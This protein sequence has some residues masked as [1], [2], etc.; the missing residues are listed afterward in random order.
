MLTDPNCSA[1]SQLSALR[2]GD[3][4]KASCNLLQSSLNRTQKDV[5]A[6]DGS[7]GGP[8]RREFTTEKRAG[9]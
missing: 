3:M 2:L 4:P 5:L 7:Q 8:E 1:L 9:P 6:R